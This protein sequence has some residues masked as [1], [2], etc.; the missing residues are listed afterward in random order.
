MRV[1]E[2][3]RSVRDGVYR[4]EMSRE[5]S[6]GPEPLISMKYICECSLPTAFHISKKKYKKNLRLPSFISINFVD[7]DRSQCGQKILDEN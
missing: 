2:D 6:I 1:S 5:V 4:R 3:E 7:I